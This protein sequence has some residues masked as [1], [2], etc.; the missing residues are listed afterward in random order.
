MWLLSVRH[1][2]AAVGPWSSSRFAGF[3]A[4]ASVGG[5][6]GRQPSG[7]RRRASAAR[8]G[9][10]AL[11]VESVAA[12]RRCLRSMRRC[13]A[14]RGAPAA[15]TF[16][17]APARNQDVGSRPP[18]LAGRR[19]DLSPKRDASRRPPPRIVQ[20]C[21]RAKDLQSDAAPK[22]AR[23]TSVD[24]TGG[25]TSP[26]QRPLDSCGDTEPCRQAAALSKAATPVHR[27]DSDVPNNVL[28]HGRRRRRRRA[29]AAGL[30]ADVSTADDDA[31][32][33]NAGARLSQEEIDAQPRGRRAAALGFT[34]VGSRPARRR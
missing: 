13:S 5:W 19:G 9:P 12:S 17:R 18:A 33:I 7:A 8:A 1:C 32:Q 34:M 16:A 6:S 20:I 22:R 29:S 26:R 25:L 23:G 4:T 2:R 11:L 3:A 24:A 10:T 15:D 30:A 21:S 27:D 14:V 28:R 31:W